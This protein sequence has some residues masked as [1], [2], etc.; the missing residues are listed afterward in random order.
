MRGQPT[1]AAPAGDQPTEAAPAGD[2]PTEAAPAA[3]Q[4]TV[5]RSDDADPW[6]LPPR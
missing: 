6:R 2:Q 3:D 1:E 5:E 4:S